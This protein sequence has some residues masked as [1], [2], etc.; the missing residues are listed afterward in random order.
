MQKNISYKISIL[1]LSIGVYLGQLLIMPRITVEAATDLRVGNNGRWLVKRDSSEPFFL[2]ADSAWRLHALSSSEQDTYFQNRQS[3]KFNGAY[4]GLTTYWN[5]VDASNA[6][7][8][9]P[10][11]D[12]TDCLDWNYEYFE[13]FSDM[14]EKAGSYGIYIIIEIGEATDSRRPFFV[15]TGNISKAKDWGKMVGEYFGNHENAIFALGQDRDADEDGLELHRA[16]AEG[17]VEGVTGQD[18]NW[19]E[20][21]SA[22]NEVLL[23]YHPAGGVLNSSDWFHNDPWLDF[24]SIELYGGSRQD[25]IYPEIQ[26]DYNKSPTK[27]TWVIEA[28]YEDRESSVPEDDPKVDEYW[29]RFSAY[30]GVFA[31]A[32]GTSYGH[33]YNYYFPDD[34]R[35]K[36]DAPGAS[37]M[38]HL[39]NLINDSSRGFTLLEPDQSV[40]TSSIGIDFERRVAMRASNGSFAYV[41]LPRGGSVTVDMT[42][43]STGAVTAQWYNPRNGSYSS[44]GMYANS[45]TR[46]FSA[47]SSGKGNDYVL[48]LTGGETSTPTPTPTSA[49][50]STPTPFPVPTPYT[51]PGRVEVENY[52]VGGEGVAYHDS[53]SG[54]EGGE[55]RAEDVDIQSCSEGG[56]NVSWIDPGEWLKYDVDISESGNYEVRLRVAGDTEVSGSV[57]LELDGGRV[58]EDIMIPNTGGWQNWT[59]IT[60]QTSQVLSSGNH[61]LTIYLNGDRFNINWVE[62]VSPTTHGDLN[63]DGVVD[64]FD[65]VIVGSC[66]GQEATGDCAR[67][68]ANGNGVVDIFDL[69]M[70]G[71]NF[72]Q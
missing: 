55:Y 71:G 24:N 9:L 7:G 58:T 18:I 39:Y 60:S 54:N 15:G 59:T 11:N 69:V 52:N 13:F 1:F 65:L 4:V 26:N 70:V 44:I 32:F 8:D 36:L 67:A 20:S 42:K 28:A 50:T 16:V 61:T 48:V 66:F 72:G 35:D 5:D 14:V 40:I 41:Y 19:D 49:P 23:T 56:Y 57:H 2:M 30:Q 12:D 51:I 68:D 46:S 17:L 64:I 63:N 31:G 45:G 25:D 34:W 33:H 53:T 29:I 27:P 21:S 3:K 38:S 37:D 10:F 6:N 47:A 22:W 43:I 62:L